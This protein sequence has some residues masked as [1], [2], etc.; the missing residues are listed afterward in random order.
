VPFRAIAESL[1]ATVTWNPE[2][3]SVTVVKDAVTVKLIIGDRTAYVNGQAVDLEV[4]GEVYQGSTMVPAR[5]I[6]EALKADVQWE[7]ESQSVVINEVEAP[8]P[9][10]GAAQE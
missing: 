10:L 3:N 2:E 4:A 5:F 6:S 7:P 8:T 1:K 9:D